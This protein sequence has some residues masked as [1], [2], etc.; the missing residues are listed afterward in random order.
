MRK[1]KDITPPHLQCSYGSCPAVFA[2]EEL[3][4]EAM[5]CDVSVSCPAAF[6]SQGGYVIIGKVVDAKDYPELAGRIGE[7]EI[8]VEV[9][10]ELIEGAVKGKN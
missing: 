3:T 10:A 4:P 9:S 1:L 5:A 6:K 2:L 8:A 7:D